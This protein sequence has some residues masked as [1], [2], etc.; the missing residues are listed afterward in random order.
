MTRNSFT[1]TLDNDPNVKG[2]DPYTQEHQPTN[3]VHVEDYKE[4]SIY[5]GTKGD[6]IVYIIFNDKKDDVGYLLLNSIDESIKL[7][8]VSSSHRR[9]GLGSKL[10]ELAKVDHEVTIH[11]WCIESF[12]K[13]DEDELISTETLE[14]FYRKANIRMVSL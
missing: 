3:L 10:I 13:R 12:Q 9:K 11:D 7:L 8:Y 4:Y 6:R 2:Y 1:Y 14:S 5:K